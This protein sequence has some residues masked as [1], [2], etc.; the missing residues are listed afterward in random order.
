MNN[1]T[2]RSKIRI[3][4][5]ALAFVLVL[6]GVAGMGYYEAYKYRTQLEYTYMR[7]LEELSSYVTSISNTLTKGMY[8]GTSPQMAQ[9]SAKLWRDTSSA[10]AA[11]TSLP[12]AELELS[13]TYK[14]LS[15]V[16]D[17]AMAISRK[18]NSNQQLTD[19]EKTNIEALCNFGKS[20]NTHIN[21]VEQK[22]Q[23]GE[24][25]LN[26]V[27]MKATSAMGNGADNKEGS[28]ASGDTFKEMENSFDGYPKLIYDGPFSDHLTDRQP[29]MTKGKGEVT[30]GQA[31]EKARK[32]VDRNVT[33][34]FE[35]M[36]NSNMPLYCFSS[37]EVNVGVTKQ[38]NYIAYMIDS[39]GVSEKAMTA[40]QAVVKA[41]EY[42]KALGIEG[43]I[44][45]YYEIANN[46]CTIN[47]AYSTNNVTCYTDLIKVGVAMDNGDVVSFDSRGFITNH[48]Q[49]ELK[50]PKISR[51]DA[52]TMVSKNLKVTS[53]KLTLI[54]TTGMN[55]VLA[56]EIK[57]TGKN[58]ESILVYINAE[59]G[60]E[61]QILI[62][63]ENE[64]GVLTV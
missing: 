29:L 15:Q 17:Y 6:G 38:G 32:A 21:N 50:A 23:N 41:K 35:Q 45:T 24:I 26:Y 37:D 8:A 30:E 28:D 46:I 10:K 7:S 2:N 25:N 19:E 64:N 40:E 43:M 55:E 22:V 58:G 59:T 61:E 54:P 12:L 51:N 1:M 4:S 20:L 14:F 63:I 3:A 60:A 42:L 5:F 56:H 48:K 27:A 39:R 16:G 53:S 52:V 49:R 9:L 47:F 13:N 31:L 36:E 33:L 62:L 34:R 18:M 11:M 57:C 44:E